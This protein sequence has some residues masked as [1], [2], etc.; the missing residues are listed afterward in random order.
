MA[1]H[2]VT[3]SGHNGISLSARLEQPDKVTTCYATFAH[4]FT[5]SKDTLAA[6]RISKQLARLGIATLRFDFAGLGDSHGDFAQTSFTTMQQDLLGA[7]NW[8]AQHYQAP[9]LL[10]GHSLGGTASLS[11]AAGIASVKG[12]VTIASPSQPAHVLHH[13][14]PALQRL[15]NGEHASIRVA[16]VDYELAPGFVEDIVQHDMQPLLASLQK[17]VLIIDIENDSLVEEQHAIDIHEWSAAHS[18]RITLYNTTHVVSDEDSTALVAD[19]ILR[20]SEQ[21]ASRED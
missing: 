16:G 21:L 14:G 12:V 15:Q 7:T 18:Q 6:Y 19:H 11:C 13:F 4:C 1:S 2:K 8:L 9:S 3:F 5:C 17:P 10:I 20:F